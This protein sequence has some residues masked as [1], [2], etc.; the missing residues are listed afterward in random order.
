M[1]NYDKIFQTF[2]D[3]MNDGII[4]VDKNLNIVY[5]NPKVCE[6]LGQS[7]EHL[8]HNLLLDFLSPQ[9]REI[10]EKQFEL[11]EQGSHQ[12][13]ELEFHKNDQIITAI[14]IPHPIYDENNEFIGSVA[15]L[16]D[17]SERKKFEQ[18]LISNEE[19]YKA[20]FNN[21][22]QFTSLLDPKG[23]LLDANQ[24]A[25]DFIGKEKKDVI[26]QYFWD[27]PWW[28]HDKHIQQDL[29]NAIQHALTGEIVHFETYHINAQGEKRYFDITLKPVI[30]SNNEIIYIVPESHDF[31]DRRNITKSLYENKKRYQLLFEMASV[32][33]IILREG[34]FFDCNKKTMELFEAESSRYF[35]DKSPEELSPEKQKDGCY[36]NIKAQEYLKAALEGTPQDFEWIFLK[37]SGKEFIAR[38]RL[39][40]IVINETRF[41]Q[42]FV[43]DITE[44]KKAEQ[45]LL[46]SEEKYRTLV[47]LAND[48]VVIVQDGLLKFINSRFLKMLGYSFQQAINHPLEQFIHPDDRSHVFEYYKKRMKGEISTNMYNFRIITKDN[49]VITIEANI[50]R[51]IYQGKP[52]SF[53]FIRDVTERLK[54]QE[55][56]AFS[57]KMSTIGELSR[58]VAHEIGNP[59]SSILHSAS[60]L[61]DSVLLAG[62]EKIL[63]DIIL[64]ET[65][66]LDE[67][68]KNFLKF[69]RPRQPE[70]KTV[71]LASIV[72]ELYLVFQNDQTFKEKNIVLEKT[73]E[74]DLPEIT[75]DPNMIKEVLWN[76][77]LNARDAIETNGNISLSLFSLLHENAS[78]IQM[79]IKD[80]G[81]GIPKENINIIFEPYFTSKFTGSGLGLA[82]VKKNISEH[83]GSISVK[84]TI[85]KGTEFNIILPVERSIEK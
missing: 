64:K 26:N 83:D 2:I 38:V 23:I 13:Y 66:R 79:I 67:I 77:F 36:S 78:S 56:L 10:V 4:Q 76:I 31:T 5:C 59:L 39:D 25:L 84:S 1:I 14:L 7:F 22:F 30:D 29:R 17:I 58:K 11:R 42:G 54:L 57:E 35:V 81:K 6:L 45:A 60:E 48:G 15:V 19:K 71:N 61:N 40:L 52:A 62:D 53:G 34:S 3:K 12:S 32:G 74:Q 24:I 70:Y 37:E 68:I 85:G 28:S 21:N 73:I 47:E 63:M 43:T 80:N 72:N 65:K 51:I 49:R 18:A 20:I 46:E 75:A 9:N 41:I 27:T 55:K 50:M 69:S 16:N 33:I 44:I 8:H 82:T